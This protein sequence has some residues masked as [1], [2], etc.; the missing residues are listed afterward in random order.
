MPTTGQGAKRGPPTPIS[1][2]YDAAGTK[3][4]PR[5]HAWPPNTTAATRQ[6]TEE[7]QH[8]E[9]DDGEEEEDRGGGDRRRQVLYDVPQDR[10]NRAWGFCLAL[11]WPPG[12]HHNPGNHPITT[13]RPNDNLVTPPILR[14]GV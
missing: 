10:P 12:H 14:N 6:G 11:C 3:M 9:R 4:M 5:H 8:T 13:E 1:C 7:P 2:R